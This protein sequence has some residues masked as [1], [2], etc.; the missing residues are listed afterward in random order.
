VSDRLPG[1]DCVS[2]S[3][4]LPVS[5]R[6]S[7]SDRVP[8]PDLDSDPGP[9]S[10]LD[11]DSGSASATDSE[12]DSMSNSDCSNNAKG[13]GVT[14]EVVVG[15][16]GEGS[17]TVYGSCTDGVEPGGYVCVTATCSVAG[18]LGL[19]SISGGFGSSSS[20]RE[21]RASRCRSR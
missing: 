7:G 2:N 21:C 9:A 11:P 5:D 6:V 18:W 1:S 16:A 10:G 20:R 13:L 12:S 8:G 17:S 19:L 14:S 3:D 4:R 15:A